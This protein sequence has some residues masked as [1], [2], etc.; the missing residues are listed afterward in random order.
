MNPL[1]SLFYTVR[2]KNILNVRKVLLMFSAFY[3]FTFIITSDGQ[4]AFNYAARLELL[5]NSNLTISSLIGSLYESGSEVDIL[6]TLI[7]SIIASFTS[8]S[9]FLFGV[10][11][12]IFGYFYSTNIYLALKH[13]GWPGNRTLILYFTVF[14]LLIGIWQIN[15]FRFWCAT[16]MF[17]SGILFFIL[18]G[19]KIM[20]LV[21]IGLSALMHFSFFA[22]IP[23]SLLGFF[24]QIPRK[25][26]IAIYVITLFISDPNILD[27]SAITSLMP[28]AIEQ[29]VSGYLDEA[30][31]ERLGDQEAQRKLNWYIVLFPYAVKI[32]VLLPLL[33]F[34][35]LE[36]NY[37]N[38]FSKLLNLTLFIA[39]LGNIAGL[40]PSG[41]RFITVSSLLLLFVNYQ[42]LLNYKSE[43]NGFKRF[44]VLLL[45]ALSIFVAVIQL[46][47]FLESLSLI[48]L[49][50]NPVLALFINP[51]VSFLSVIK[52]IF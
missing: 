34:A 30:V 13:V 44:A 2:S 43:L 37:K 12:L 38:R 9:R 48:G 27:T 11:G 32:L 23:I 5:H 42:Y 1:L 39:I 28:Y 21:F 25:V 35:L 41:G 20:G 45:P 7:T 31:V 16:H 17:V 51:E 19:R 36:D 3:G 46:R 14:A 4:D 15:G 47:L 24:L 22:V 50:G 6:N 40:Y 49:I 18:E 33:S 52:G 10:Y 26:L 29:R 8:D